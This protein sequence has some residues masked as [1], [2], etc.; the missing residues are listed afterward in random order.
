MSRTPGHD[1]RHPAAPAPD[2]E[3]YA[4]PAPPQPSPGR[5]AN[6]R[7]AK[8]NL[9]G[10][11]NPFARQT[12]ALRKQL[13]EAVTPQ[14]MQDICTMLILRAKGGSVPHLKLLFSYIIGK[15]TDAVDPDTL[16]R[17]EMEQYRQ[18]LGMEELVCKVGRAMTPQVACELVQ[19]ARPLVMSHIM[20]T[21]ADQLLEGLPPEYQPD[22]GDLPGGNLDGA[23]AE[24][25]ANGEIGAAEAA[26]EPAEVAV[27]APAARDVA[28][29][30]NGDR[31]SEAPPADP[32]RRAAPSA[33]GENRPPAQAADAKSREKRADDGPRAPQPRR[34]PPWPNG[35][36]PATPPEPHNPSEDPPGRQRGPGHAGE[37]SRGS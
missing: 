6:G 32:K 9:G 16:D 17:Q 33:N 24:P 18:E 34:A 31:R 22:P 30:T 7:F 4:D 1:S 35:S 11:G 25:S 10:P 23:V 19:V 26:E 21:L 28:P 8:G 14:D 36:H 12:A 15:P 37:S 3:H 29:S 5:E 2:S 27:P 13:L 20:N